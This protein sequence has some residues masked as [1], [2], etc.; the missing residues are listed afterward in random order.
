[1]KLR[2]LRKKHK[3]T[4]AQL[5]QKLFMSQ[6]CY[7]S[8]ENGRTE[9]NIEMLCKIANFYNVSVDYLIGHENNNI[10]GFLNDDQK[11]IMQMVQDLDDKNLIKVKAYIEGVISN[12]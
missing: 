6:N 12:Q 1:M 9:P 5:A 4:Q 7:S 11:A 2:E 8:Y 3:L 10:L